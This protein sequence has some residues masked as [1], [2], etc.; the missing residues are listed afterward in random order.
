MQKVERSEC[1]YYYLNFQKGHNSN[2][3]DFDSNV[4]NLLFFLN[5]GLHSEICQK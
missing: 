2:D 5:F 1:I 4:Q 3:P